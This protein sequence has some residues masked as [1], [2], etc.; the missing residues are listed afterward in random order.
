MADDLNFDNNNYEKNKIIFS[1][2]HKEPSKIKESPAN[3]RNEEEKTNSN[4]E[5]TNVSQELLKD[6]LD[7]EVPLDNLPL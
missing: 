4:S 6:E 1:E 5:N 2:I 7:F 3:R